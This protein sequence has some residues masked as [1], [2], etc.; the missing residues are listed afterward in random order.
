MGGSS[1][2]S[3]PGL[4]ASLAGAYLSNHPQAL[5]SFASA[6]QKLGSKP[7]ATV[8]KPAAKPPIGNAGGSTTFNE[9]L[10]GNPAGLPALPQA[11]LGAMVNPGPTDPYALVSTKGINK[12]VQAAIAAQ[13][14]PYQD[15][16]SNAVAQERQN[17]LAGRGLTAQFQNNLSNMI[18][19]T[20][21]GQGATM[22]LAAQQGVADQGN[23]A[24]AAMWLANAFGPNAMGGNGANQLAQAFG[25]QAL[26]SNA[27]DVGQAWTQGLQDQAQTDFLQ[28]ERATSGLMQQQQTAGF[29]SQLQHLLG[30]LQL[31]QARVK[32]Q[33]PLL[34][35]Q[36]KQ[37]DTKL[38]MEQ[39]A[40]NRAFGLSLRGQ[41]QS[42]AQAAQS[43]R[44]ANA[45][46]ALE[47]KRTAAALK[48]AQTGKY[49]PIIQQVLYGDT[50]DMRQPVPTYK[51]VPQVDQQ[52][53]PTGKYTKVQTGFQ[54]VTQTVTGINAATSY[55][56]A[57]SKMVAMGVPKNIA[58]AA[59][60][61]QF[62]VASP[63]A[64][65]LG[66]VVNGAISGA[67][68][69]LSNLLGQVL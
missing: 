6:A 47:Q 57:V 61:A 30:Q 9:Q 26:K 62:P 54:T 5:Q 69:F 66:G 49:A 37:E 67:G 63:Q 17:V 40:A 44:R 42:E 3:T 39:Q 15:Q 10:G 59:A 38:A 53:N 8:R 51:Y 52:G 45:S 68:D 22:Q 20:R 31:E 29:R 64:Q 18:A 7:K 55:A 13:L 21:R 65:A 1:Q 60:R 46:L 12:A 4:L 58:V 2:S 33:A 41:A 11:N 36:F 50:K 24:A 43:N 27:A 25:V 35:R 48:Q 16:M 14:A 32:G 23:N 19:A 56:D 28:R 34:A